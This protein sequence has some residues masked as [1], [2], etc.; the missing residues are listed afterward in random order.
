MTKKDDLMKKY[1]FPLVE[2]W[3][4]VKKEKKILIDFQ[5]A[6]SQL[7]P[8]IEEKAKDRA[9][10]EHDALLDV[11]QCK[12][13]SRPFIVHNAEMRYLYNRGP[14]ILD[15]DKTAIKLAKSRLKINPLLKTDSFKNLNKEDIENYSGNGKAISGMRIN[16][17]SFTPN[18]VSK[19]GHKEEVIIPLTKSVYEVPFTDFVKYALNQAVIS[20]VENKKT[21][22][23]LLDYR[24]KAF[25]NRDKEEKGEDSIVTKGDYDGVLRIMNSFLAKENKISSIQKYDVSLT[26]SHVQGYDFSSAFKGTR[27]NEIFKCPI[28]RMYENAIKQVSSLPESYQKES[29]TDLLGS[30]NEF[31]NSVINR[32]L[33]EAKYSLVSILSSE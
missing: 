2:R 6:Y 32:T 28:F 31:N 11:A 12:L 7:I 13:H 20:G 8:K 16:D 9:Q 14:V 30:E 27:R 18:P 25:A 29:L 26:M 15:N 22:R 24:D 1:D 5:E 19:P 10:Q 17:F 33:T 4:P 21:V 3:D 23:K